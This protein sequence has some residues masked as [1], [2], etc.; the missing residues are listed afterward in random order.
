MSHAVG[1]RFP[2]Y[3]GEVNAVLLPYIMEFNLIA[4]P[5]RFSFITELLG[6]DIT[7]LSSI[8]A[9]RKGIHYVRQLS[10]DIGVPQRLS[11]MGNVEPYISEMSKIALE[12][13][14][15]IT[16]PRDITLN[17]VEALFKLAL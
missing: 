5:E 12:D 2:F 13:A 4:C 9:G 8:E 16:N 3:H 10:L 1:G 15:M 6:E 7:G 14:C 11:E 17:D